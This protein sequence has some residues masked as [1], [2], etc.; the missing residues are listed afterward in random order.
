[1]YV[2]PLRCVPQIVGT[3]DVVK[4]SAAA[5]GQG[6]S[7]TREVDEAGGVVERQIIAAS[8]IRSAAVVPGLA[9]ED[10]IRR[11]SRG[12]AGVE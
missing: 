12:A 3:G 11:Q 9:I 7:A 4:S 6:E 5:G 1:M 10:R 2:E 8:Q